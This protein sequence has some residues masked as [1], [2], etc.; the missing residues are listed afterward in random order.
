MKNSVIYGLIVILM[1]SCGGEPAV[2]EA[3]FGDPFTMRETITADDLIAEM[4]KEAEKASVEKKCILTGVVSEFDYMHGGTWLKIKGTGG[5]V[6][7]V[8]CART[9][10]IGEVSFV[11]PL[12]SIEYVGKEVTIKGTAYF[13][14]V[15]VDFL[16]HK[17]ADENKSQ[18]EIDAIVEEQYTLEFDAEGIVVKL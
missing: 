17:A 15:A 14:T 6:I 13:N 12:D 11:L 2:T 9:G 8:V 7:P 1:A 18:A 4:D 16:K 10:G 3:V 5:V